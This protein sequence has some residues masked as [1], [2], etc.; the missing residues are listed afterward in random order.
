MT[1]DAVQRSRWTFYEA[2]KVEM[3]S[4]P[5]MDPR[6]E[7]IKGVIY[8]GIAFLIWGLS[9]AYW[10]AM[11]IIPALEIV[12][13]RLVWSFF[14]LVALSM[15]QGTMAEFRRILKTPRTLLMLFA[16]TILISSNWFL[17]VWAVN[18]GYLLQ[19]S[20]GYFINPLVNILLGMVFLKE[21]L[22]RAQAMAVFLAFAGVSLRILF[23]G[24]FPWVSLFLAFSFG[25]YGLIRKIAP[26]GALVGLAVETLLLTIPGLAYLAYLDFHGNGALF[27]L[28]RSMDLFLIGTGVMTAT[29]LLFFNMGTR[30]INLSTLGLMQ[31][32]SPSC[33]FL[34]AVLTFGETFTS[35]QLWTFILIWIALAIYSIDSWRASKRHG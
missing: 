31:Y 8:S 28:S 15:I 6:R 16:T 4:S 20:L 11:Q 7:S 25:L 30:R 2:V 13:H 22:S 32:I 23:L 5:S 24:E 19:A 1:K 10:K 21:R 12:T 3:S 18:A 29:P 27:H 9:P 33:M 34:L 17:Y 26:A 35:V 14:F